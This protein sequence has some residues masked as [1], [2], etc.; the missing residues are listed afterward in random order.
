MHQQRSIQ[1]TFGRHFWRKEIWIWS[2]APLL[3]RRPHPSVDVT[4]QNY[5]QALWQL[6]MKE[7]RFALS[8]MDPGEVP[9]HTSRPI[10]KNALQPLQSWTP[11]TAFTGCRRHKK[12]RVTRSSPTHIGIGPNR[13]TSGCS[14]RRTQRRL[15]EE[16]RYCHQ[17][18]GKARGRV[19][20]KQ[21]R[22][23]WYGQCTTLLGAPCLCLASPLISCLPHGGLGLCLCGWFL[24][25]PPQITCRTTHKCHPSFSGGFWLDSYRPFQHLVG[26]HRDPRPTTGPDGTYQTWIGHCSVG[27]NDWQPDLHEARIGQCPG[28]AVGNQLLPT[29][30]AIPSSLLAMEISCKVFR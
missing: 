29:H 26:V 19:V 21:G 23:L 7:T 20:D 14:W 1:T 9:M 16:W 25:A 11:S 3:P 4:H 18:G 22:N 15:T 13:M 2:L 17:S 12:N 30:K 24:L 6:L 10:Q 5:A 27:Q 8:M 28:V